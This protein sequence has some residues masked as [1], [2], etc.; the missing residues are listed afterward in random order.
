L[1]HRLLREFGKLSGVPVLLNTSFNV[2][3]EPVVE[4]PIHALRCFFS[5]GLDAL[6]MGNMIL[7]KQRDNNVNE[8]QLAVGHQNPILELMSGTTIG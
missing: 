3:D 2:M 5:T 8:Y 4:S 6:V 7:T 1:F